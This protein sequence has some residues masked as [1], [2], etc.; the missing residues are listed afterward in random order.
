MFSPIP[1]TNEGKN[2]VYNRDNHEKII[3]ISTLEEFKADGRVFGGPT[4]QRLSAEQFAELR[5]AVGAGP[6]S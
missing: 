6:L 2:R 5:R 1:N 3:H 4:W